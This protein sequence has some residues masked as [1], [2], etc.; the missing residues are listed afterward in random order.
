MATKE[1]IEKVFRRLN[2][3]HPEDFFQCMSKVQE[4]TGAVLCMLLLSKE[5][6]TAGRISE[7]L[8]ISTARVAVL[9]KKM[10]AKKLIIREKNSMDARITIVKLSAYGNEKAKEIQREMYQQMG[11]V[12][13]TI[14]EKRIMEFIDIANQIKEAVSPM[15]L[16]F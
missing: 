13:D 9:L 3:S 16:E 12:L 15:E 4:G 6:V 14:G 7:V 8:T 10:E 11:K 1:Q 5:P 2:E